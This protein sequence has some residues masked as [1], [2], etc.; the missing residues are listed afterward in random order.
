VISTVARLA[1]VTSCAL[2]AADAGAPTRTIAVGRAT[3]LVAEDV[4]GS[5]IELAYPSEAYARGARADAAERW[6]AAQLLYRQAADAWLLLERTRPSRALDL[7]ISKAEHE[8]LASQTLAIRGRE[9]APP[10]GGAAGR[11]PVSPS[12]RRDR[13]LS[14]ARLLRGKVMAV[15]AVQRALPAGLWGHAR[16]ELEGAR[17]TDARPAGGQ[18]GD[19]NTAVDLELCAL[20]AIAGRLD[21]ARA[22]LDQVA[23]SARDDP[24]TLVPLAACAAALGDGAGAIAALERFTE[25][26]PAGTPDRVLRD[27]YLSN[28]WD[29]LR[30]D[31]R[32]ET[33]F[34]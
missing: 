18:T 5:P 14:R 30:G 24:A 23:D 27:V 10:V 19:A 20:D 8:A 16:D 25:G 11:E 22:S 32:F 12:L 1:W 9:T 29:R 33:L 7:A 17:A 13:A 21:S 26:A 28:D 31:Q 3:T 6:D 15:R 4:V 34:P 2:A